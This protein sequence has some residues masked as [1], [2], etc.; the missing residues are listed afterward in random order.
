M[1]SPRREV[2]VLLSLPYALIKHSMHLLRAAD[3]PVP[4]ERQ[5]LHK[6]WIQ[7]RSLARECQSL[8]RASLNGPP[9]PILV[10]TA[11]LAP[12]AIS[13]SWP[14][15]R[16]APQAGYDQHKVTGLRLHEKGAGFQ[17]RSSWILGRRPITL[18]GAPRLPCYLPHL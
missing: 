10:P 8:E 17:A 18:G 16:P 6:W 2:A 11:A 3:R 13:A 12:L 15:I 7:N 1:P 5:Q 9:V 14:R 4:A